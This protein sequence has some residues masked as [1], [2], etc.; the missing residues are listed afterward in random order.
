M[1]KNAGMDFEVCYAYAKKDSDGGLTSREWSE[2]NKIPLLESIGELTE[3]SDA[4]IVLS[5]DNPE[6]HEELTKIPLSSGKRVYVDKVFA[7]DA[8]CTKRMFDRAEKFKTPTYSSSALNF[9]DELKVI[10]KNDISMITSTWGGNFGTHLIHQI[11][12]V[13]VLM[14][15]EVKRAMFT[16]INEFP[17]LTLE[18]QGG[19]IAH[20]SIANTDYD[21]RIGYKDKSI[22]DIKIESPYFD[23]FIKS[24]LNFFETG[25]IPVPHEQTIAVMGVI[26]AAAR[27]EKR[28]FEWI[29]IK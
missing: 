27:A 21:M 15:T 29:D 10:D 9:A 7:P 16:G 14:G 19:R 18:F 3:K 25:I 5:P 13:I 12:P 28:P 20:L 22:K 6:M 1:I 2:K 17:S 4:I 11:E 24:M 23:N 8:L 26:E